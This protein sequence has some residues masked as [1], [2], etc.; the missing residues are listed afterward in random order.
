MK[1]KNGFVSMTLVYTFLILF[2]FL[3]ASILN[4]YVEKNKFLEAIDNKIQNDLNSGKFNKVTLLTKMLDDNAV[5]ATNDEDNKINLG[6]ISGTNNGNGL[7]STSNFIDENNDGVGSTIYFYR[8]DVD[9]NFVYFANYCWRIVRTN[10]NGST[11]L[12]Y[13]GVPDRSTGNI[14]CNATGSAL[15]TGTKVKFNS[16]ANDNAYV[17][18]TYGIP[19][20]GTYEQTH[21]TAQGT[22]IKESTIKLHLDTWYKDTFIPSAGDAALA[23]IEDNH[24]CNDRY[25]D[26]SVQNKL[27]SETGAQL[28]EPANTNL[29]GVAKNL[30]FYSAARLT[31][32]IYNTTVENGS[33][34][35]SPDLRCRNQE[36]RYSLS[37]YS[38]GYLPS[39]NKLLYY[40]VGTLT[41]DEVAYA[42][43]VYAVKNSSYYINEGISYWTMTPFRFDSN[44]NQALMSIVSTDGT[45][46]A[47]SVSS[48][49]YVR[50][51]ISIVSNAIVKKG[52]GKYNSP[53]IINVQ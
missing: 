24:F 2:L 26:F 30:T 16:S 36:D 28:T 39:G 42:G 4:I 6:K 50:P 3:M 29:K 18:Y 32:R 9:N 22:T 19:N 47:D 44:S 46:G 25:L 21:H 49:Y 17:G 20:S 43:G 34:P 40:P 45:L 11:K 23:L 12:L 27:L 53:Y 1:N 5:Y 33:V 10:E 7:Y 38:G 37:L 8:G 15:T 13:A 31:D 41:A 14:I 48:S 35:S 51:V 52:N